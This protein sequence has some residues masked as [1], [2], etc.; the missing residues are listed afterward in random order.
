MDIEEKAAV[1]EQ[2]V[3]DL[4][5]KNRQ[6]MENAGIIAAIDRQTAAHREIGA[7]AIEAMGKAAQSMGMKQ[8]EPLKEIAAIA[9]RLRKDCQP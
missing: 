5:E 6:L 2:M 7:A 3:A 1:L 4:E 9:A 8:A